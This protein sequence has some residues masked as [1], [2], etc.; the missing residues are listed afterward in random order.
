MRDLPNSN[1][2]D[3]LFTLVLMTL[4]MGFY[5]LSVVAWGFVI[6]TGSVPIIWGAVGLFLIGKLC[7]F[8]GR[9]L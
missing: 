2:I 5:A 9:S 3:S 7:E 4:A 1:F 6:A 8:M